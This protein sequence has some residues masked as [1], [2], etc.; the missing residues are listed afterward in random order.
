MNRIPAVSVFAFACAL[1][2]ATLVACGS[3]SSNGGTQQPAE[4]GGSGGGDVDAQAGAAGEPDAGPGGSGGA[5]GTGVGGA[6]GEAGSTGTTCDTL[7]NGMN[8]GFMVDGLS[9]D[10]ILDL[11][12]GVETGGPPTLSQSDRQAFA[13]QLDR[14]LAKC[15]SS[16]DNPVRRA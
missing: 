12:D 15:G 10:F 7:Q 9:R 14:F 3:D 5:A 13:N 1:A 4:Q 16:P 2:A 8:K 11:P 6:G